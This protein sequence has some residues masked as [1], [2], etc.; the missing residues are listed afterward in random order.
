M[1]KR[2]DNYLNNS[3]K[4]IAILVTGTLV[5]QLITILLTPL[6][7]RIYSPSDFGLFA[8]FFSTT[9]ILSSIIGGRYEIAIVQPKKMSESMTLAFISLSIMLLS[10][11]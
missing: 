10:I 6:L 8:I 4:K 2:I 1:N 11:A 3:D 7:S 9:G 5:A